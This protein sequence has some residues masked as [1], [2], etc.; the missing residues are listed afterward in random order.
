[1]LVYGCLIQAKGITMSLKE[2]AQLSMCTSCFVRP[3]HHMPD[4]RLLSQ[5]AAGN[6]AYSYRGTVNLNQT[7]PNYHYL[8]QLTLPHRLQHLCTFVKTAVL[9]NGKLYIIYVDVALSINIWLMFAT[10]SR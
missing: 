7:T 10:L 6:R 8:Y 9:Y 5:T 4:F 1:M 3:S 2:T